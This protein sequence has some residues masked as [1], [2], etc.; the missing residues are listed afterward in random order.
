VWTHDDPRNSVLATARKHGLTTH[1]AVSMKDSSAH[2]RALEEAA[3]DLAV[4][5]NYRLILGRRALGAARLGAINVHPSL[6]PRH[7]G[8]SPLAWAILT[9]DRQSGVTAILADEGID[10]GDIL[11]QAVVPLEPSD[12]L[13]TLVRRLAPA[14]RTVTREVLAMARSGPLV[15]TPQPA[16]EATI[17]RRL[18]EDDLRLVWTRPAAYLSR[19]TLVGYS[20]SAWFL[21]GQ[22]VVRV[23]RGRPVSIEAL[24]GPHR[25]A[26][27]VSAAD[28]VLSDSTLLAAAQHPS[29]GQV[30]KGGETPLVQTGEGVLQITAWET[31]G[32]FLREGEQLS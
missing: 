23:Q 12:D 1:L 29:P 21:R 14:V 30:L 9:G 19:L 13:T 16:A 7:R 11:T 2:T 26:M 28:S 15:G 24:C 25:Q 6:L 5:C 32:I 18:T 22:V 20:Q 17:A 8:P 10:T 27:P 3:V 4:M 31:P